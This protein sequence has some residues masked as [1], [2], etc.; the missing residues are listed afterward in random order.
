MMTSFLVSSF[1][2]KRRCTFAPHCVVSF[3]RRK[4]PAKSTASRFL[5][6]FYERKRE[7]VSESNAR[8]GGE[9]GEEGEDEYCARC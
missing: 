3:A 7:R 2:G 1:W 6:R 9:A 5:R 4:T 8:G